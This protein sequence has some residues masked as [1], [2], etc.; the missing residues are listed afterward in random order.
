MRTPATRP[1]TVTTAAADD[2]TSA[3]EVLKKLNREEFPRLKKLWADT[4]YHNHS[5]ILTCK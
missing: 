1:L 4:K 3:P 2:E 5:L